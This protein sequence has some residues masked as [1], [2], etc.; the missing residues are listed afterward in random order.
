[1]RIC[2]LDALT[3]GSDIDLSPLSE[4]GEL[5]IYDLTAPEEIAERI[6]EVDVVITNKVVLNETNLKEA[7]SLK[8]IALF[9]TGYN[10]IDIDYAKK[11][12]IAVTNVA[13]YSTESVAQHTFA[14]LLYLIEHLGQYD[15][16]VKSKAYSDSQTFTYIAWP[17][18]ELKDKTLGIIGLGEIGK[19]VARI[20]EAFGMKITYYST[21]GQNSSG[22]AYKRVSLEELLASSDV[23]SIHAPYNERTH[24]L[25][26]YEEIKQMKQSAYLLNLGRGRIIV[27]EDLA[28]ALNENLIAG[29]GL[30]VLE[31]EP[32]T[33][34]N[35]LFTVV[36]KN[37]L[38]ITPH[39][40]WA[41]VE[42][43]KVLIKEVV[44]NIQAY[45]RGEV[46]NRIV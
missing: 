42:A 22:T 25:I 5:I 46:R 29:A 7:S 10:N 45:E 1:M 2:V 37:K 32:I 38:L 35:P 33:K 19:A 3:V 41:S 4:C 21:S 14:M 12:G 34:E 40:A 15:E 24:H 17:F 13:G 20:G 18:H 6:K 39:I 11:R 36:D 26:G 8:M 9:A 31:N 16:Y 23:V 30:D 28:R 27:E 44:V 43:R